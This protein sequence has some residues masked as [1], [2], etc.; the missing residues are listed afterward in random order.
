MTIAKQRSSTR[1]VIALAAVVG[2]VAG[3]AVTA[4]GAGACDCAVPSWKLKLRSV[5]S[6]DPAVDHTEAWPKDAW[7]EYVY[8][9]HASIESHAFLPDVLFSVEASQ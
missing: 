6:S 5:S 1:M 7:L 8:E 9:D 4:R 3:F 2:A